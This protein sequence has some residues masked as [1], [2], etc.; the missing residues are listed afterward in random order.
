MTRLDALTSAQLNT[1]AVASIQRM[2]GLAWR[3]NSGAFKTE[4]KGKTRFIR[5]GATGMEDVQGLLFGI[6]LAVE[7]KGSKDIVK[8]EQINRLRNVH[9]SGGLSFILRNNNFDNFVGLLQSIRNG[10]VDIARTEAY[11]R[12]CEEEKDIAARKERAVRRA[13]KRQEKLYARA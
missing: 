9:L 10:Y 7:T 12:L 13:I 3:C 5:F 1:E 4:Y 6:F 8:L 11:T 2:G